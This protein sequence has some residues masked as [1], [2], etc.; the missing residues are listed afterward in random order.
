M[1]EVKGA[2]SRTVHLE[3]LGQFFSSLSLVILLNLSQTWHP[4]LLLVFLIQFWSYSTLGNYYFEI[5]S[6]LKV[7]RKWLKIS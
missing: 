1:D 3:K 4:Y 2:T 5:S 7:I 6:N